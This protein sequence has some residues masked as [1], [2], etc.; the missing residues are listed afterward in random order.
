MFLVFPALSSVWCPFRATQAV[1][2]RVPWALPRADEW[3][4]F[5]LKRGGAAT[6]DDAWI[7]LEPGCDPSGIG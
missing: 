7:T 2:G 3:Q 6:G 5:G 4:P 1:C